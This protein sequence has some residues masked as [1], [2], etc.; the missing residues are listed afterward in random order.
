[1]R[2]LVTGSAG[3]IG[4]HVTNKLLDMGYSVVGFDNM[5]R[6][7]DVELKEARLS[8][9]LGRDRFHFVKESLENRPELEQLFEAHRFDAVI[10]LAAQAGVRYSLEHPQTY[11]DSNATGFLNILEMC[12]IHQIGHLLYASSSSVYGA[13]RKVPFSEEDTTDHP[14]SLYAATKKANEM[15]AH[16]Y[17]HIYRLPVT[18]LRFF[19]VYGP[20]GRPDM[21]YFSFTRSILDDKP[22]TVFNNGEMWRDFTYVDD[23][24]QAIVRLI[25]C[26]PSPNSDWDGNPP[27]LGSS[28]APYRIYNIG[29][30]SPEKLADMITLLERHLGRSARIDY[31]PMHPG[32]VEVTFADTKALE[33]RIG[34]KP[35]TSLDDGLGAFVSWYKSFYDIKET[36]L[37]GYR[38]TEQ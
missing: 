28:S 17:S 25:P 11:I 6:Y 32:D 13:N 1:M 21:A 5:N 18:G 10:H 2:I 16:S 34:F 22:I 20:W 8:N 7:Y 12:R 33:E 31:R 37:T 15:M 38:K 27:Q 23:V 19:T 14:V 4:F 29:N 24:V 9:L 35:E 26:S 36:T 3:F 30:H